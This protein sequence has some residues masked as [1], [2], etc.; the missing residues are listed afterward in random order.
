M[1]KVIYSVLALTLSMTFFAFT[2]VEENNSLENI[3][4]TD[5]EALAGRCDTKFQNDVTF[6][7]CNETYTETIEA[8]F[9]ALTE[10]LDAY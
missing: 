9:A 2:P 7:K 10:V 3:V 4:R 5:V 6:S 8:E 1:K